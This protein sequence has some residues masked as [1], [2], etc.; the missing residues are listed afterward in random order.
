MAAKVLRDLA[1]ALVGGAAR[2]VKLKERLT[3]HREELLM[4]GL[5]RRLQLGRRQPPI[6]DGRTARAYGCMAYGFLFLVDSFPSGARRSLP[7][8]TDGTP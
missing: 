5:F 7:D 8:V 2:S 6:E 3:S 1:A 4:W